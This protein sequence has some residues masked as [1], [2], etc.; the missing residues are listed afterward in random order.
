MHGCFEQAPSFS[1]VFVDRCQQVLVRTTAWHHILPRIAPLGRPQHLPAGGRP[2]GVRLMPDTEYPFVVS[3]A[4]RFW[5]NY[6]H[7]LFTA[8]PFQVTP[9]GGRPALE[10]T[11][12]SIPVTR[13]G[14][15]PYQ[16]RPNE[17]SP[18]RGSPMVAPNSFRLAG[19]PFTAPEC[20]PAPVLGLTRVCRMRR[21]RRAD[22][23]SRGTGGVR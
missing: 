6:G 4:A 1:S 19:D 7:L 22:C 17:P 8:A 14:G 12:R 13:P 5:D 21:C 15:P 2:Y 3:A 16:A 23:V 20:Y 10:A 18:P 9:E 11:I